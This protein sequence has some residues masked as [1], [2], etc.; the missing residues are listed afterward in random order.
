VLV[1]KRWRPIS[2]KRE[3]IKILSSVPN[4]I[5]LRS[6]IQRRR[7]VAPIM[8]VA[9]PI[10]NPKL[11]AIPWAKTDHGALP[12]AD[13][14]MRASPSPKIANPKVRISNRKGEIC[15][16]CDAVQGICGIVRCGR[17]ALLILIRGRNLPEFVG[18]G[19]SIVMTPEV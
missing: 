16:G 6:G 1:G 2:M 15:Q 18:F 19:G 5:L 11:I 10:D 9:N 12:R 8:T 14:M 4:P 3:M 17:K 7:T 13:S